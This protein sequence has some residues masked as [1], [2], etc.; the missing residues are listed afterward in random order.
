MTKELQLMLKKAQLLKERIVEEP[1][2][3]KVE[4]DWREYL[5]TPPK[6]RQVIFK[7]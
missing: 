3:R 5:L 7:F 2:P 1:K 4:R 6:K